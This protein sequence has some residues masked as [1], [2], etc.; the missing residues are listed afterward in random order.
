VSHGACRRTDNDRYGSLEFWDQR[1][2]GDSTYEWYLS[3]ESLKPEL[4]PQLE[5]CADLHSEI[6][7]A[8]C[9][10]ST[11]CEDL[12]TNGSLLPSYLP[13]SDLSRVPIDLRPRLLGSCNPGDDSPR[14]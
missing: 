14:C 1:Y 7:V 9:G 10:N 6:V 12:W 4:V 11:L 5:A 8:G 3:Y 13:P 2:Q